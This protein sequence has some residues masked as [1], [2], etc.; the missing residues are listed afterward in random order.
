MRMWALPITLA[1]L[2]CGASTARAE[3]TRAPTL[4]AIGTAYGF[5]QDDIEALTRGERVGGKLTSVSE[6]ELALSLG[7][8]LRATTSDL[9][10]RSFSGK[11][12]AEDPTVLQHALI[13]DDVAASL[14]T[15]ELSDG[16]IDLLDDPEPG[17]D[18]N[19]ST[20]EIETF[21]KISASTEKGSARREALLEGFRQIL[22]ARVEAYR[23]GGRDAIAPYDRGNGKVGDPA[24]ELNRALQEVRA[25]RELAP[26]AFAAITDITQPTAEGVFSRLYWLRHG[27][28]DHLITTLM[29]RVMAKRGDDLIV[30]DHRFYVSQSLNSMQAVAVAWGDGDAAILFYAN[31]VFTDLVTGFG[32][33]I[34]RGIGRLLMRSEV[35]GVMDAYEQSLEH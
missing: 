34:A 22:A 25:T 33:S 5:S 12:I 15:L 24:D 28:E 31:R 30:I 6:N 1:V 21:R 3:A 9:W 23:K 2:L 29:H 27:A 32:G 10:E 19:L 26:G 11:S 16:E 4:E 14:A 17:K 18:V 7:A 8:R 20:E 13:E 35:N